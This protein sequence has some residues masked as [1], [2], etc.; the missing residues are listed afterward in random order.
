MQD[1]I[2]PLEMRRFWQRKF[3]II[4]SH[5]KQTIDAQFWFYILFVCLSFLSGLG[6]LYGSI[7]LTG[8]Q[9]GEENYLCLPKKKKKNT[10]GKNGYPRK[11]Y[12]PKK[13]AYAD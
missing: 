8:A 13:K 9:I 6:S 11:N 3:L 4:L 12:F 2:K 7:I 10:N 1:S 5:N